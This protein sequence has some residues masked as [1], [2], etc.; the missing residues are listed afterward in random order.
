MKL[1]SEHFYAD[2]ED[3]RRAF[4][5]ATP[6]KHVVIDD[7]F[8]AEGWN[9]LLQ[10]FPAHGTAENL[11][12]DYGGASRKGGRSDLL[13]F[14]PT[15]EFWDEILQS[16]EFLGALSQIT[17]IPEL[18]YDPD[19]NGAGIHENF[20]GGRGNIHI[21]YNY[22]PKSLTHRRLNAIC[23][24]TPDW[25]P[26]YGGGLKLYEFGDQPDAGERKIVP[27]LPNRMVLFE[28]TE[29]SWHGVETIHLPEDAK[30]LTRKSISTYFYTEHRPEDLTAPRHSTIYYPGE[31]SIDLEEGKPITN[32]VLAEIRGFQGRANALLKNLYQEHSRL[33]EKISSYKQSIDQQKQK[34]E[35]LRSERTRL[36]EDKKKL[37]ERLDSLH[38]ESVDDGKK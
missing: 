30:G 28:T 21:D 10:E 3:Y 17:D 35:Q 9:A 23:Y 34:V 37:R 29:H 14:G 22:H 16:D 31:L 12:G 2:V 19:Y 6:F 13:N 36:L 8:T 27:C 32:E 1:I 38:S 4:L 5:D 33:Y 20:E 11:V 24:I 7:F 18:L 15:Y 26:S 25:L